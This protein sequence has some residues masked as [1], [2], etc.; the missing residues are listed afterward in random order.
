MSRALDEALDRLARACES[1]R[2]ETTRDRQGAASAGDARAPSTRPTVQGSQAAPAVSPNPPRPTPRPPIH[3][4]IGSDEKA[5]D[6]RRAVV[7]TNEETQPVLALTRP[8]L[9]VRAKSW[10]RGLFNA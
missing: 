10:L 4:P 1:L 9:L 6:L 7:E 5:A 8:R 3:T 2:P